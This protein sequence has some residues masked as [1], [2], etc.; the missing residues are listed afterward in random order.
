VTGLDGRVPP[1]LEGKRVDRNLIEEIEAPSTGI[2]WPQHRSYRN[3]GRFYMR[4]YNESTPTNEAWFYAPHEGRLLGYDAVFHQ[5]LGS[6]GPDGF[7]PAGRP[8]GE[9][10]SGRPRCPTRLWEAFPPA[11]L[12]FPGGVYDV[13]FARRTIR[14]L[15]T[16]AEGDAVLE[17]R[18]WKDRREKQSLAIVSTER[19]FHVLTLAG[20]PVVSAPRVYDRDDHG[21]RSVGRLENPERYFVWYG[22]S[23]WM[24]PEE[25]DAF[26]SHLLEYD[27]AGKEIARR[28]L[29]PH[30]P[31]EQSPALALFG[32][33]TPMTEVLALVGTTRHLRSQA[34]LTYG[35]DVWVLGELLEMWIVHFIPRAVYCADTTSGVLYGFAALTLLSAAACALVNYLLARRYAF[36]R[37]GRAGWALGGF[38]FG[39]VGLLLMLALHD[40]PAR[41]RCPSC[42]RPRRVDRDRCEHCGAAHAAPALDGT[43]VFEEE[44]APQAALAGR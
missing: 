21:A 44:P 1:D 40:W 25:G 4:Y 22:K 20:A 2:D 8:P 5:F 19:A 43:E 37:A 31:V 32:L 34:R 35:M 33:A 12:V 42:G 10:F 29:P 15:F 41:V 14:K 11:Y 39:W 9:R 30:P 24:E 6:F 3:P 17:A 23:R 28:T 26:P 38:L 27:G 16:P 7:V 18:R 36:S 13:D